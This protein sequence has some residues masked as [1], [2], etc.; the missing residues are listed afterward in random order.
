[1]AE[2]EQD[3]FVRRHLKAFGSNI[4]IGSL[5]G[6][7][8]GAVCK[9]MG[10]AKGAVCKS[11]GPAKGAV[12][13][14]AIGGGYYIVSKIYIAGLSIIGGVFTFPADAYHYAKSGYDLLTSPRNSDEDT[15]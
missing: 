11:M 12:L 5:L 9:S 1:M 10:P 3:S 8:S 14:A 4:L 6:T 2:K 13:G 7:A 15:L